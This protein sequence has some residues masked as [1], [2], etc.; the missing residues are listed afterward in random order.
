MRLHRLS[1]AGLFSHNVDDELPMFLLEMFPAVLMIS[2]ARRCNKERESI[3]PKVFTVSILSEENSPI[4]PRVL[5]IIFSV[6][7]E[8]H[9][10]NRSD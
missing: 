9:L 7:N 5:W 10:V 1:I 6:I 4:G 3:N 8:I 2:Y